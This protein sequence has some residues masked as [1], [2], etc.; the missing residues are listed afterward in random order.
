MTLE[1]QLDVAEDHRL[2]DDMMK[3]NQLSIAIG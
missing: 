1:N 2:A 3:Q